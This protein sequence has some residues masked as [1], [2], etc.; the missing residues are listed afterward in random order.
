MKWLTIINLPSVIAAQSWVRAELKR[1]N[2]TGGIVMANM[3][4]GH[5]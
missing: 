1:K 3:R 2:E 4:A 5:P